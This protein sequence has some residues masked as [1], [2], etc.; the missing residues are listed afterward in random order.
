MTINIQSIN[1]HLQYLTVYKQARSIVLQ[2]TK[3]KTFEILNAY[4]I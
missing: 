2:I 4:Q 3:K 1:L